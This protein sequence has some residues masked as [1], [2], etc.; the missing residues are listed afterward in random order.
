MCLSVLPLITN[1]IFFHFC[2]LC[3]VW[4]RPGS[5]RGVLNRLFCFSEYVWGLSDRNSMMCKKG[6]SIPF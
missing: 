4:M 1:C 6:S 3:S 2:K 5:S